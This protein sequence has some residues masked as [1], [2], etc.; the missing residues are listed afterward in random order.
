MPYEDRGKD[1]GYVYLPK[2][3]KNCWEPPEPKRK[4]WKRFSFI[5]FGRNQ[6]YRNLNFELVASLIVKKHI[7][8]LFLN[9]MF[10]IICFSSPRK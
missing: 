5:N 10:T 7:F 1:C 3:A 9:T 2:K 6:S 8:L 4:I